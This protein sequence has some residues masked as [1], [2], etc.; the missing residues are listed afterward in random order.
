MTRS[1]ERLKKI[2]FCLDLFAMGISFGFC[3][4]TALFVILCVIIGELFSNTSIAEMIFGA[5]ERFGTEKFAFGFDA[6]ICLGVWLTGCFL[7][8]KEKQKKKS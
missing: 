4:G 7:W 2:M 3:V 1:E 8:H 6:V 5:F